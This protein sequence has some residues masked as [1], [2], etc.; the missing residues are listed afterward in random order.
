MTLFQR[1]R[2]AGL[3][4]NH[5]YVVARSSELRR[6][7]VLKVSFWGRPIALFRA[8]DGAL[9]AIENRCLH[10]GLEL[11]LGRVCGGNLACAYHGWE[12]DTSGRLAHVPHDLFGH[13]MPAVA[14]EAFP[15]RERYGF[16]W[17]FPGRPEQAET[18]PLPEIPELQGERP[19]L[20]VAVD[21]AWQAHVSMV[22]E[23]LLDFTHA[24]LHRRYRPFTAGVLVRSNAGE[25]EVVAEYQLTIAAER[26]TGL[27]V[28]RA[29]IDTSR[30]RSW[31]AYPYQRAVTG[32]K[33]QQWCFLTPC[34]VRT[35]RLF[36][37]VL[38][39]ADVFRIPFTQ[40]RLPRQC[41]RFFLHLSKKLMIAPVLEQD[42]RALE[43]EQAAFERAP[44]RPPL[45]FSP[46]VRMLQTLIV[47]RWETHVARD[48]RTDG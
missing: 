24:Y 39:D 33:I 41:A 29:R 7:R 28:N 31:F 22:V 19:W 46:V 2:V 16:I 14:L 37:L 34:D 15:L 13:A 11:T 47:Q 30:T 9:G 38:F 26:L 48:C 6:G 42:G 1:A 17:L 3:D 43:A 27:F 40:R 44:E 23:N 4:P 20:T 18:T 32:G 36:L 21:F 12:Y 8:D 35:T 10:R 5:W 25:N 45:E